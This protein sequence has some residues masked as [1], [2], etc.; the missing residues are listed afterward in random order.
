MDSR[1][2]FFC[3]IFCSLLLSP[4]VH[5]QSFGEYG[6]SVDVPCS[7]TKEKE[8]TSSETAKIAPGQ[9]EAWI[10]FSCI[11]GDSAPEAG[12]IYRVVYIRHDTEVDPDPETYA[13]E[14]CGR[15]EEQGMQTKLVSWKGRPACYSREQAYIRDKVFESGQI[16]FSVGRR[17]YTLNVFTSAGPLDTRLNR[18]KQ[19]FQLD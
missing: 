10:S 11:E 16:N 8:L 1:R 4:P 15:N 12:T 13:K 3:A 14:I 2:L 6:F 9:A 17:S 18:L 7:M 19:S 5:G